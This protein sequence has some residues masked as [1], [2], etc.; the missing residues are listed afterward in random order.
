MALIRTLFLVVEAMGEIE[1]DQAEVSRR[2]P[3]I[4]EDDKVLMAGGAGFQL[5]IIGV[6]VRTRTIM[7]GVVAIEALHGDSGGPDRPT[8][9]T[10]DHVAVFAQSLAIKSQHLVPIVGSAEVGHSHSQLE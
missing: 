5:Q 4:V 8:V 2:S 7:I 3:F 6:A 10:F 9:R 1:G